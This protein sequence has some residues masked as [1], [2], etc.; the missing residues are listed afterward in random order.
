MSARRAPDNECSGGQTWL[1]NQLNGHDP[2]WEKCCEAHDKRY[3]KGGT[4]KDR[5]DADLAL[6]ACIEALGYPGWAAVYYWAVRLFGGP[7][8][9]S[10]KRWAF[11][12]PFRDS[13]RYDKKV[14][15]A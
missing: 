15:T 8:W 13:W 10:A 12:R 14:D 4:A 11:G 3:F 5:K 7:H 1:W 6:R 2:P 9:P